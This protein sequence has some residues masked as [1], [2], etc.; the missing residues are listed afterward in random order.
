MEHLNVEKI[1]AFVSLTELNSEAIRLSADVNGH[2]RECKKCLELV[3]S[4][5]MIYDEFLQTDI[6]IDFKK[7][8]KNTFSN[9]KNNKVTVE[10]DDADDYDDFR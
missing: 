1:I 2:I 5:Q 8:I 7:Y 9:L 10:I 6:N 4:F 3:R